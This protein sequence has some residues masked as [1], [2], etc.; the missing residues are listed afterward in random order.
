MREIKHSGVEK[1]VRIG[2]EGSQRKEKNL[3]V[4]VRNR[5]SATS[6]ALMASFSS[7]LFSTDLQC[8]TRKEKEENPEHN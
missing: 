4:V 6:H 8:R 5:F 3:G 7:V 2:K 1:F